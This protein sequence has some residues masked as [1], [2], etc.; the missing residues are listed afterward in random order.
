MQA[1]H[2]LLVFALC[3]DRAHVGLLNCRP[4]RSRVRGVG[5]VGLHER[6]DELGMQQDRFMAQRTDLASPPVRTPARLQRHTARPAFGQ[7]VDQ[8]RPAETPVNDLPSLSIDPVH[9]EHPLC[10]VQSI[11][12][13]IHFG[14]S[15][16]QVAA[17]KLHFGTSMPFGSGGPQFLTRQPRRAGVS[18]PSSPGCP[19]IST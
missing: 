8:F 18:I 3:G 17:S 2:R 5:L 10:N 15:V 7:K 12:R 1:Q 11:R 6:A 9:L 4:D 16:P 14:P 19:E 13:S